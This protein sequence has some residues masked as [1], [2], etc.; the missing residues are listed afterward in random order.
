[1]RVG[2]ARFECRKA[3]C[4]CQQAPF[5]WVPKENDVPQRGEADRLN[6]KCRCHDRWR[7][8]REL[9]AQVLR[10]LIGSVLAVA[11]WV[12]RQLDYAR[13]FRPEAHYQQ[14][15]LPEPR[16]LFIASIFG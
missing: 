16:Q 15:R 10:A 14:V 3:H 9:F 7:P 12:G 2:V 1:V 6:C 13:P 5:P 8:L 4:C 11:A